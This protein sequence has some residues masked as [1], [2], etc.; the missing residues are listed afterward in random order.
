MT[1]PQADGT[2][3]GAMARTPAGLQQWIQSF[4]GVD[5]NSLAAR[6]PEAT[7]N[8]LQ[9]SLRLPP[10]AREAAWALLAADAL[11]T[12]GV[13]AAAQAPDP[14]VAIQQVLDLVLAE[15]TGSLG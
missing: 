4:A 6:L 2:V 12:W 14:E 10:D 9:A 8:A 7:R 3:N 1:L 15:A 11:L 5:L 13:E